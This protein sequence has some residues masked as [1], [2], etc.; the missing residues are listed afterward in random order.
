MATSTLSIAR[1]ASS[2]KG[3]PIMMLGPAATAVAS[4]VVNASGGRG[5][6]AG[7]CPGNPRHT[8]VAGWPEDKE[9]KD[10]PKLGWCWW[11]NR[12]TWIGIASAAARSG[13]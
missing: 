6:G 1:R 4:W 8:A 5:T 9:R 11:N 10:A 2:A 12:H 13:A 3:E 7:N